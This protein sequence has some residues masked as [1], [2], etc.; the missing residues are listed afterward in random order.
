MSGCGGDELEW[1][2]DGEGIMSEAAVMVMRDGR[3]WL[4]V[5][6]G[7]EVLSLMV[8]GAGIS[9]GLLSGGDHSMTTTPPSHLN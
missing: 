2:G 9:N 7:V 4:L 6:D 1:S 5:V 3:R 8:Q